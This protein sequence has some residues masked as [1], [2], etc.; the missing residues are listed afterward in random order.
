MLVPRVSVVV[1]PINTT[2]HPTVPPGWRW[3]VMVGD[4]PA[5]DLKFCANAAWAPNRAEAE[6]EGEHAAVAACKTAR[7]FGINAAY[8]GVVGLD[9]DPTPAGG[10]TISIL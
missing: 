9:T 7:M 5:H 1:H 2:A 3:A 10:D 6:V 8:G 4:T